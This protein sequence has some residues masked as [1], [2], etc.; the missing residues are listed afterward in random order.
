MSG[1]WVGV[2]A[3]LGVALG[4]ATRGVA[5]DAGVGRLAVQLGWTLWLAEVALAFV[6]GLLPWMPADEPPGSA[7]G[8]DSY[9]V[10]SIRRPAPLFDRFDGPGHD[11]LFVGDSFTY[12]QGVGPD[13]TLPSQTI[14]ALAARGVDAEA[15]NL[16]LSG[17]S[18]EGEGVL[19]EAL[20]VPADP[21]VV[22][23]VFVLN[24]FG[25]AGDAGALDF[26]MDRRAQ[27]ATGSFL[28][29]AVR[30]AVRK[31]RMSALTTRAYRE[32]FAP[33]ATTRAS[34]EPIL[35]A[36]GARGQAAGARMV[37]AIYPLMHR[38]DDYPF[39]D[40][41]GVVGALGE[42]AGFEVVDL[43]P[44]F[45]G[46]DASALW[47]HRA[48]QH[49]NAEGHRLAAEHLAAALAAGPW[50]A[51]A[52]VTWGCAPPMDGPGIPDDLAAALAEHC[53]R[54]DPARW[55]DLVEAALGVVEAPAD[56]G[57]VKHLGV[58]FLGGWAAAERLDGAAGEALRA[59][60][61]PLRAEVERAEGGP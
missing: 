53:R 10:G 39:R 12:G 20:G 57:W 27:D 49:P 60:L 4:V 30:E 32:A 13:D 16:G 58:F 46:R 33:G 8:K 19:F 25:L 24:D 26:I 23:W 59:R 55:A 7:F 6:A 48:D 44:A 15:V 21:E 5:R 28:V 51:E 37:L 43:L 54:E 61:G 47:V 9:E 1:V 18:T 14:A 45:E 35:Q 36:V 2:V 11:L 41:H 38:L 42:A 29:D 40:V 50:P 56:R 22:V 3:A 52:D 31:G 34:Q 17:E